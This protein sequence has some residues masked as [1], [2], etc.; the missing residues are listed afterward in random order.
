ML[1]TF[2]IISEEKKNATAVTDTDGQGTLRES[3]EG[4]GGKEGEGTGAHHTKAE[5]TKGSASVA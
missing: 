4:A 1:T 3:N 5:D 2:H